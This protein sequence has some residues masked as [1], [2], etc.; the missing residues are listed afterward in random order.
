MSLPDPQR[1][2]VDGNMSEA[3]DGILGSFGIKTAQTSDSVED[4]VGCELATVGITA[5]VLG[6]RFGILSLEADPHN[7]ELLKWQIDALLE[8]LEVSMPGEVQRINVRT[9][10]NP[11]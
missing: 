2:V 8:A 3:L 9:T 10:R 1:N 5:T 4:V 11:L 6:I 7:A